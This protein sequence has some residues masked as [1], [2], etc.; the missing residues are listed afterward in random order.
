ML[1]LRSMKKFCFTLLL[2]SLALAQDTP[3]TMNRITVQL[4]GSEVP[5][6]NFARKPKTIYRAGST[7]CRVEE[8]PDPEHNIRGLLI[9]NEPN[10]WMVNLAT[11]TARHTVDPGPTFN[12]HLP[13][14]SGPVPNTPDAV[15]YSKLGLEFGYELEYFKKMGAVRQDPGPVLQK[16]QTVAYF[17]DMGGTRFALF[18]Y[19]PNE[20]PLLV[21]HTVGN[22]GEMFWY[23]GYGQ[24]PFDPKLFAKP[25]GVTIAEN[26]RD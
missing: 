10:A 24:V 13:I 1:Q 7:Y 26:N 20:F 3:K 9:V 4:D 6:N 18:I 21:A 16:Q 12:C 22:K 14:F 8:A 17:L 11:K 23:S 25:E 2:A 5:Q 19:G 15:D